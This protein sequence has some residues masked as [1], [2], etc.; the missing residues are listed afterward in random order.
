MGW[1]TGIAIYFTIWWVSLFAV[2]PLG[3]R[4]DQINDDKS[5][6]GLVASAP[7]THDLKKKLVMNSIVAA[8]LWLIVYALLQS[9]WLDFF[10]VAEDWA[11]E[12]GLL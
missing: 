5:K 1:L 11:R 10:D 8:V 6:D 7:I 3:V 12:D 4:H 2:L 9:G